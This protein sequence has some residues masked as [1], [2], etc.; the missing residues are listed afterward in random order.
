MLFATIVIVNQ[1]LLANNNYVN[2]LNI[3]L[4]DVEMLSSPECNDCNVSGGKGAISCSCTGGTIS[5]P[6]IG[7]GGAACDVTVGS[8]YFACCYKD[9]NG[10]CKCP[11]CPDK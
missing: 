2:P 10:I 1:S 4:S 6:P 5:T 7:G 9:K 3:D 11:S 8:G